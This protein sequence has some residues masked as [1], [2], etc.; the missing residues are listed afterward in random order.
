MNKEIKIK[1]TYTVCGMDFIAETSTIS[2]AYE[3]LK[4]IVEKELTTF[5]DREGALSEY[6]TDLVKMK[7]GDL[8]KYENHFF[9]FEAIQEETQNE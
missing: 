8:L 5:P 1:I 6:M 9:T 7:N 4:A 3:Y 2:E